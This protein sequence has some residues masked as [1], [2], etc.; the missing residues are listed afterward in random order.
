MEMHAFEKGVVNALSRRYLGWYVLPRLLRLLDAPLRGLGLGL[1]PG[2][3][4]ETLALAR[5]FPEAAFLGVEYDPG[6][7]AR[8]R[9]NLAAHPA[10]ATRVVFEQGDATALA[11]PED[12]FDF[13]YELNVLHHIAD[14]PRALREVG[15]VLRPGA[16]FL[17]QDLSRAFFPPGIRRLFPPESL[18]TR[19]ELARELDA[20]GFRVEAATGR[21]VLFLRARRR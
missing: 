17:L 15:R 5:R 16:P 19:D 11:F 8:A 13:A 10:L 20:A 2:V 1:G 3:G 12:T 18:F 4:W 14:P 7:V 9:R 21:A 6:Q